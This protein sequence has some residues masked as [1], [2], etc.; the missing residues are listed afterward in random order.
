[1]KTAV[2]I[3]IVVLDNRVVIEFDYVLHSVRKQ[4]SSRTDLYF[5]FLSS[6]YYKRCK[7]LTSRDKFHKDIF[8]TGSL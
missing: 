1:M 2:L 4:Y 8:Y 5:L 3:L 6:P 7:L